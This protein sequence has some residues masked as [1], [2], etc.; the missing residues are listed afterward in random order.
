MGELL[1]QETPKKIIYGALGQADF[2][3]ALLLSGPFGGGKTSIARIIGR[4]LT[5]Q[6][7]TPQ[8]E[9]C[10]QCWNC[11]LDIAEGESPNYHEQDAASSGHVDDIES[12]MEDARLSPINSPR[13]VLVLDE[14]HMLSTPAQ[15]KLLKTLE[16]GI[17]QTCI[18]LAT[19]NPEKLLPTIRSRCI[20]INITPVESRVVLQFLKNIVTQENVPHEDAALELIVNETRGH[21]RNTLNLAYQISLYGSITFEAVKKH[22]NLHIEDQA[23]QL[24]VCVGESWEAT[25]QKVEELCQEAAPED[26]WSLVR[27]MVGKAFLCVGQPSFRV[28]AELRKVAEQHGMRLASVAEWSLGEGARLYIKTSF[29]LMVILKVLRDKLGVAEVVKEAQTRRVG[30]SKEAQ[31]ASGVRRD[32]VLTEEGVVSIFDLSIVEMK[33]GTVG[34]HTEGGE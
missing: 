26:L 15:N 28:S 1:G 33:N 12:L 5:C 32:K 13:K 25:V 22:L 10:G 16:D 31:L 24:L 34:D 3:A 18:M 11:G 4:I 30:L 23:C 19:T 6:N 9:A 20:R 17:G 14:A 8:R 2:P 29:D 27:R 7:L 21:I